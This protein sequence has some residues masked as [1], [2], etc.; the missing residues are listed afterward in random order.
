[1]L[2]FSGKTKKQLTTNL[3]RK[4]RIEELIQYLD[5]D[6]SEGIGNE[7]YFYGAMGDIAG[8]LYPRRHHLWELR[9]GGDWYWIDRAQA[10]DFLKEHDSLIKGGLRSI[11]ESS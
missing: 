3:S 4:E 10:E 2:L 8:K 7:I 9:N 5:L 1:M 6:H 11:Y